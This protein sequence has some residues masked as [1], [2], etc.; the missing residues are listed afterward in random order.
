MNLSHPSG[1]KPSTNP[2]KNHDRIPVAKS[3]KQISENY[4]KGDQKD[5]KSEPKHDKDITKNN[6]LEKIHDLCIFAKFLVTFSDY[7]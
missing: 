6:N 1:P 7:L 5:P 4:P 2:Y 3:Y